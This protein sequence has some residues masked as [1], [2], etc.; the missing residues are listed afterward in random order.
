MMTRALKILGITLVS[1]IAL[2]CIVSAFLSPQSHMERSAVINTPAATIYEQV[3]SLKNSVKWMPWGMKD[4]NIKYTYAGPEV[5][6]GAKVDWESKE[7][8]NGSQWV[9]ETV[10]DKHVKTGMK[11][12]DFD[13]T[14]TSEINLEPVDGGTKVTWTYDGDVTGAGMAS[15]TMGKI[16]G[17]F[18]DGML[19]ADYEKG[20]SNLKTLAES[21]QQPNPAPADSTVKK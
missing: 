17:T 12:S 3:S 7:V 8:G 14:Y 19:G 2:I 10:Q 16:M 4:P 20:L 6:V 11:F 1:L 18:I 15:A 21:Q 5:G 9:I 13:G